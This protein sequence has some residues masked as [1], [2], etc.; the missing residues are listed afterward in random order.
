M[1]PG[2]VLLGDPHTKHNVIYDLQADHV[3]DLISGGERDELQLR[4]P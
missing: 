3:I 4:D 1:G 2:Y